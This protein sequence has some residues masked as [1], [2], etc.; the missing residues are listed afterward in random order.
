MRFKTIF[1]AFIVMFSSIYGQSTFSYKID[2]KQVVG[3][4]TKFWQA[5]GQDFLYQLVNEPVGQELLDRMQKYE[6]CK[7]FR[8][9]YTFS[10]QNSND[11]RAGGS[12][13]GQVL[14]IDENGNRTYNFNKV[15]S[16]FQE[17]VKRGMKPIVELD[18]FPDR[19]AREFGAEENDEGFAAKRGEPRDWAMW[20]ELLH[21][22]MQNL[23]DTFGKEEMRTWY[24]EVW[25]EPD[26][27]DLEHL[28]VFYRLYDVFAA[29]V[30]SYDKDF[31]VGGPAC[32]H[33][34][35][36]RD[37][38]NHVTSGTNFVSGEKGSPLDFVSYH[39]YGLSGGWL[40]GEPR[41]EP[42]VQRFTIELLWLQRLFNNY[43][44]DGVEFHL[45][46]W[47][48][49][50]NYWRS[51]KE[52]P[53][54]V[55]RDN[56][57]GALFM[58]KLVDNLLGLEGSYNLKTD[59]LGYWGFCWEAKMD[60]LF[61]G[62]RELTTVGNIPKPIL[63]GY[64]FLAQLGEERLKVSG[65]RRGDRTGILATKT[66]DKEIQFIVY[67]YEET[68]KDLKISDNVEIV[69]SNFSAKKVVVDEFIL[70]REHHNT[71]RLWEKLGSPRKITPNVK[72]QLIAESHLKSNKQTTIPVD[73]K[74][75]TLKYVLPRHSMRLVKI[76]VK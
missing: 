74:Q 8:T 35:F 1:I 22:F 9:H 38:L 66:G 39:I 3:P 31:R 33:I 37:F 14:T 52:Y 10:N 29:V 23:V 60:E 56:E 44:L 59:L 48:Q 43:D 4:N 53:D 69:L 62:H 49:S 36:M 12:I 19:M 76:L 65:P 51:S 55:Y 26:G 7:Y 45:N 16:T 54:L 46:E 42:K 64:E 27:W 15:N 21:K 41:I 71:Y 6:S 25:N 11:K 67:N 68:D 63:T 18:F 24:F 61:L 58:T 28:D 47:G 75:V 17:Y 70:D 72:E 34:Y 40:K 2:T 20:E 5:I 57:R 13:C 50:S 32:Y 73:N 30:K